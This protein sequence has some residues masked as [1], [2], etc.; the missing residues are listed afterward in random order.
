MITKTCEAKEFIVAVKG[1][2]KCAVE[3][4]NAVLPQFECGKISLLPE[5]YPAGDEVITIYEAT[6]RVIPAGNIPI[7]V[8]VIVFSVETALN[9][10]NSV[11]NRHKHKSV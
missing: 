8:G 3:A 11:K 7:T 5:V 9:I 4:V 1:E 10:Y 6:G 2:Y